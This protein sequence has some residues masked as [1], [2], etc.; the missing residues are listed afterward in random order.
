MPPRWVVKLGGSLGDWDRLPEWLETLAESGVV[1]V[2]GGG[3]FADQ[4]RSAQA[5]WGF[6]DRTAHAM[7]I[8]AMR[9]YG[10]MLAALCPGFATATHIGELAAVFAGSRS[11]IWLPDPEAIPAREVPASWEITSDSLAAWLARNLG[12]NHLLLVKSA[13]IPPGEL[14]IA[15]LVEEAWV[16]AAFPALIA[17]AKFTAWVCRREDHARSRGG[18]RDPN[19]IF[20][21]VIPDTGQRSVSHEI[22]PHVYQ[23]PLFRQ[24]A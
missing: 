18:L 8:L 9:Q 7:A 19:S 1:L 6:G 3:P 17:G 20:T 24:P 13:A 5:R 23:S 2:P 16:D 21:R 15:R 22:T 11:A 10:L 12:A 14:T 4:V